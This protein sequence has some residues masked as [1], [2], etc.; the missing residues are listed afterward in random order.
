MKKLFLSSV[1]GIISLLVLGFTLTYFIVKDPDKHMAADSQ[2]TNA[3]QEQTGETVKHPYAPPSLDDVPVGEEGELIKLGHK[4]ATETST[5]L[6]GYVGNT[7]SCASCHANGGYEGSLDLVGI[8]KTYPQY[9]P[10]AGKEVTIEDRINGCFKRSMNGKP[11]PKD[12]QEMKAM[13]AFYD[14]ISQNVPDGTTERPWAKLKR[15][16]ADI[17]NVDIEEGRELYNKACITCHGENGGQGTPLALWGDDSYNIG[18]GMARLRTA[19]GFIKEYMPKA[20]VGGYSQGSLTDEEAMNIAAYINA[21]MR[22]DFPDKIY[23]WPNGDAPDDAAYE[24]IAG[25]KKDNTAKK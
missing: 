8:S 10:R 24:T 2:P 4:Y 9:N 3:N 1:L 23:D 13:V 17:E 7:L 22:P 21:Q 14:Y 16:E 25:K 12:S 18:A 11:L 5:A 20:E 19:A 6:D 15:S